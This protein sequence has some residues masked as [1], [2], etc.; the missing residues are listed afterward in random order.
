MTNY[1]DLITAVSGWV[2]TVKKNYDIQDYCRSIGIDEKGQYA[3][4]S[5]SKQKYVEALLENLSG[6]KLLEKAEYIATDLDGKEIRK[7]LHRYTGNY[8]LKIKCEARR[9]IFQALDDA[10][11][12]LHGKRDA[13]NFIELNFSFVNEFDLNSV[14]GIFN[15]RL[16]TEPSIPK[17]KKDI[18]QHF[19]KNSDYTSE[20]VYLD[21]LDFEYASDERFIR[22]FTD[23]LNPTTRKSGDE[24]KW[25]SDLLNKHLHGTGYKFVEQEKGYYYAIKDGAGTLNRIVNIIFA[26]KSGTA[27]PEVI[28]DDALENRIKAVKNAESCL[29]YD[30]YISQSLTIADLRDWWASISTGEKLLERMAQALSGAEKKVY[31]VYYYKFCKDKA[32]NFDLPALLPQ[33]YLHYDPK[34]VRELYGEKRT[35]YQRMDFL[36]L[37]NGHRII[38]EIDDVK[39]YSDESGKGS[40]AKY[41][42]MVAYDRKLRFYNYEVFRIGGY[43]LSQSNYENTLLDFFKQLSDKYGFKKG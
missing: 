5:A 3:G 12:E 34:T 30:K 25:L 15:E 10:G 11:F 26:Q 42:E 8:G 31:E 32:F 6:S 41:A 29:I 43:E 7:I 17:L 16:S 36:I 37:I 14:F 33:V 40:P 21:K 1:K 18:I 24:I 28:L 9:A 22:I 19:I 4:G 13:I 39:H 27:K 2:A 38:I 23:A 20:Q 35:V